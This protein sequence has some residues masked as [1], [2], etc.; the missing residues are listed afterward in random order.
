MF[1]QT[2]LR[3]PAR[4]R[5]VLS[6]ALGFTGELAVVGVAVMMPLIFFDRLPP[7]QAQLHLAVPHKAHVDT[8][9]SVTLVAAPGT[10]RQ[11][12]RFVEP[13]VIP[14]KIAMGIKDPPAPLRTEPE[15]AE[16][17]GVWYGIDTDENQ[18]TPADR[19]ALPRPATTPVQ[20]AV[21]PTP[22]LAA[23]PQIF[24][25]SIK[26]AKLI[27]RVKP[28]YPMAAKLARISG[29]VRLEAVIATDGG[30]RELRAVSGNGLLIPAAIDAV[31]QWRY[32]PTIL[33]GTPVE[34]ATTI[35]VVFTLSR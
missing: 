16:N 33:N 4:T 13:T 8:E 29:T 11:T 22:Q 7:L 30:I 15:A 17:I 32:A 12:R 18:L 31:R 35:D 19:I 26:T 25:F 10:T 24:R 20:P 21:R 27:Y 23:R 28:E 5:R 34:I 3:K 2:L 1:E 6:V 14:A 9:H